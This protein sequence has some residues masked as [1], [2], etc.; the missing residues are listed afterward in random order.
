[1]KT[2][3]SHIKPLI[4]VVVILVIIN[5]V[6][7]S[8]FNRFDF[9]KDNRYT[10]SEAALDI[11][12]KAEAP[13]IV[14][15]FLQGEFPS[16]FKRLQTETRSIL[17][18]FNAENPYIYFNFINPLEGNADAE[19]IAT[20]FYQMGMTPAR[21]TVKENGKNEQRIIFPWAMANYNDETVKIP[22]L[23]NNLGATTEERVNASVQQLEYVFADAFSKLLTPR[24]QKIAIMRGNGELP[25]LNIADFIKTIKPYYRVAPFTLDSVANNPIGTLEKL[26]EYDLVIEAKPTQAFTEQEKYVLDQYLMQ[27]GKM[28]WLTEQVAFETDSLFNPSQT[29]FALPRTLNLD[30]YFFKYGIRINTELVN[31]LY[32]APLILASGQGEDTQFNPYPWFYFPLPTATKAHPIVN[33]IEAVRFEY[34]NPIDTLKNSI[35]KTVLLTSSPTTKLDAVPRQLSLKALGQ[36][37][38][39]ELY[40]DSEQPLAVLLEGS[41]TSVYENR[42]KPFS[43]KNNKNN[44]EATAMLVISDG[45]IIKNKTNGNQPLELGFERY[46]GAAYGNKEFLLNSVNYLLDDTGLID[47]RSKEISIA[48]LNPDKIADEKLKWQLINILLP[49]VLLAIFGVVFISLRKRKYTL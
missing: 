33:N 29:S 37:P 35:N 20:Q 10:L 49:L 38:N 13:L 36:Q 2:S 32:S 3:N 41:F 11:T 30:D 7:S 39:L 17:E 44:S 8:F 1:M 24:K 25:D 42:L 27:G 47:I 28:L 23:K 40:K 48:F 12:N 26:N 4:L 16:E 14:D 9:T 15:V 19:A 34:A 46:T 18:E 43:Y 5:S 21:V 22:L 6:S 45:D 31:D